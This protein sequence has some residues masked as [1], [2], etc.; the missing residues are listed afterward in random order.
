V[1]VVHIGTYRNDIHSGHFGGKYAALK[2]CVD[3]TDGGCLTEKEFVFFDILLT[4][5][6][7]RLKFPTGITGIMTAIGAYERSEGIE[8]TDGEI[9]LCLK[10]RTGGNDKS[11]LAF[12]R[13]HYS[14]VS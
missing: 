9:K 12:R 8:L 10:R 7:C 5:E 2:S 6:R 4:K 13:D 14:E 3:N 11:Y 1:N